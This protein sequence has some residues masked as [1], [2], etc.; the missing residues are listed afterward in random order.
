[1]K[2]TKIMTILCIAAVLTLPS[3]A[4]KASPVDTVDIVHSGYGGYGFVDVWGGGHNDVRFYGGVYM[5]DK[6][7]GTGEGNIWPNGEIGSF[8]IELHQYAPDVTKTYEVVLPEQVYNSFIGELLGT[9]KAD[10]ISE[11]WAAHFD[12]SWIGNETYNQEAEAFA[13]AIW[14]II[15]ED[16]PASPA[17]WDVT[18]DGTYGSGGFRCESVDAELANGWLRTLD[19]CGP[20]ADLRAFVNCCKQDYIVEV[21]EPATIALLGVSGLMC[22]L[23]RKRVSL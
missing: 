12:S 13:A 11:L 7:A 22:L 20:K 19:G 18:G 21:P 6:T 16:L 1:M 8:C 14:E 5:I 2:V 23:R 15:Y 3:L 4:A 10:Y 9:E 17:G